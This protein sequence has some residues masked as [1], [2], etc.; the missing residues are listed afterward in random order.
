MRRDD[1]SRQSQE[2]VC[3]LSAVHLEFPA[4]NRCRNVG[5]YSRQCNRVF[6]RT[7]RFRP[8]ATYISTNSQSC[9]RIPKGEPQYQCVR[10]T[11]FA[12]IIARA[13]PDPEKAETRIE[14]ARGSI[15]RSNFEDDRSS[16]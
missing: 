12:T 1:F 2:I 6:C 9:E 5:N 15:V 4:A 11:V 8:T 3:L 13:E 7:C 14:P 16:A 10:E